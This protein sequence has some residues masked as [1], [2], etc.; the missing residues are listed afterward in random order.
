MSTVTEFSQKKKINDFRGM[1]LNIRHW[2]KS[3]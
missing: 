3:Y 1:E 2:V